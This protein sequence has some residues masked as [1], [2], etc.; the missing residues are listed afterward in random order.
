M[1]EDNDLV[2]PKLYKKR[3]LMLLL[4]LVIFP[5]GA[6]QWFQ[7]VTV[8]D[9]IVDHYN[10]SYEA[11]NWTNLVTLMGNVIFSIP[12]CYIIDK[13][14][15]RVGANLAGIGICVA[16]WLK[17]LSTSPN[18]FWLVIL[19]Q[20]IMSSFQAPLLNTPP[21][22][23][24]NWFGPNEISMACSVGFTSL[25]LGPAFGFLMSAFLIKRGTAG[26]DLFVTNIGLAVYSTVA[27]LLTIFFYADKPPVPPSYAAINQP[28]EIRYIET[29]KNLTKNK[30][31]L[32]ILLAGGLNFSIINVI[33]TVLNQVILKFHPNATEDVGVMGLVLLIAGI[34]GGVFGGCLIDKFKTFR[35][36]ALFFNS[37]MILTLLFLTYTLHMNIIY[38]YV[39]CA[40][41]GFFSIANLFVCYQLAIE[42]SYPQPEAIV[43]GAINALALSLGIPGTY[44]YSFFF[45]KLGD[46][47]ANYS[48]TFVS[49]CSLVILIFTKI[50]LKRLETNTTNSLEK[51]DSHEKSVERF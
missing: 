44:I 35:S 10:V 41:F 24:A 29:I 28:Q 3:W 22:L 32:C 27:C 13:Y 11:V 50:E 23:A 5:C 2:E 46:L 26:E 15:S 4:Y 8:A 49:T 20:G 45:Y 33:Q 9:V 25:Q 31:Y 18:R 34:C 38:N 14:G 19:A 16:T 12:S 7:Y 39:F 30:S 21:K 1:I 47:W 48:M 42:T 6:M 37:S 17:V 43:V 40:T 51:L 36:L